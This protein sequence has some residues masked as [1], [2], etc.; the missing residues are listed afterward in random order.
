LTMDFPHREARGLRGNLE[1]PSLTGITAIETT[2]EGASV[3][4]ARRKKTESME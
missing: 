2:Y 3:L 1:L 4:E